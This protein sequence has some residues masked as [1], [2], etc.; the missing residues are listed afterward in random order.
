V[1]IR[2]GWCRNA[3]RVGAEKRLDQHRR[4]R[5]S[6]TTPDKKR[7]SA[8]GSE[9]CRQAGVLELQNPNKFHSMLR[10]LVTGGAGLIGSHIVDL[11]LRGRLMPCGFWTTWSRPPFRSVGGGIPRTPSFIHGDVRST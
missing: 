1:G 2:C 7:R 8:T 4:S 3:S 9:G 10:L 5:A 6:R 11:L